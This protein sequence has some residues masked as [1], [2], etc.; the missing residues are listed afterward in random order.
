MQTEPEPQF[1]CPVCATNQYQQLAVRPEFAEIFERGIYRC[2][3]CRF[4][5]GDPQRY[6]Q[7][8]SRD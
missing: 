4:S 1:S 8:V 7:R 3:Q 5:F 2:R 6:T